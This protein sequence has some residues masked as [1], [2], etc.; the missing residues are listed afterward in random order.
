M[1]YDYSY[2]IK[3]LQKNPEK[4]T[5]IL[6]RYTQYY[7]DQSNMDIHDTTFFKEYLNKFVCPFQLATPEGLEDDFDWDLLVKLIVASFSSEYDLVLDKEWKKNPIGK[8]KV[9]IY[10]TVTSRKQT[11]TEDIEELWSFQI[12]RMFEIYVEE[13]MDFFNI[14]AEEKEDIRDE[15]LSSDSMTDCEEKTRTEKRQD[16]LLESFN[17]KAGLILR[18]ARSAQNI[19]RTEALMI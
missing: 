19:K 15:Q 17:G 5:D 4:K 16:Q 11:I 13:Q 3:N 1:L 14:I 10:V 6:D 7:G 2:H 12:M 8:P 18:N 9:H